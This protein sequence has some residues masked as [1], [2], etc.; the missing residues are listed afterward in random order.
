MLRAYR[1]V[2]CSISILSAYMC[3]HMP[4]SFWSIA[5]EPGVS[6]PPI[7]AHH[8]RAF[9]LYLGGL[10][11]WRHN[12]TKKNTKC[13]G[14]SQRWQCL[15]LVQS[16]KMLQPAES[17]S[18]LG[19]GC[20]AALLRLDVLSVWSWTLGRL[21]MRRALSSKALSSWFPHLTFAPPQ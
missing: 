8:L 12:K 17:M 6:G 9:L 16:V 11:V 4:L 13:F 20:R 3:V 1:C 5:G 2:L 18:T 7:T 21:V 19:Y 14:W 15:V 10:T